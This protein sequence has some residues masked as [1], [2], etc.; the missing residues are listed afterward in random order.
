MSLFQQINLPIQLVER[1]YQLTIY[2]GDLEHQG[3]PGNKW[4]KLKHNIQAAKLAGAS[5]IASFGGPFSNHLHALANICADYNMQAVAVVRGELQLQLTPTLK[6]VV[7]QGGLLWPS[8]RSDYRKGMFSKVKSE[9]EHYLG[10]CYWIPEGGSN[11]LGVQ[12]CFEWSQSIY[13]KGGHDFPHWVISA[14]TGTTSAGFLANAHIDRLHVIPAI[15]GGEGLLESIMHD[16]KCLNQTIDEKRLS[17]LADYHCGGYAKLP[18][19]LKDV[20]V[21]FSE[22]NP[23]IQFDPVYTAKVLF[24]VVTEMREGRWPQDNTLL[25]HTG[26]L[27]GLR[28]YPPIL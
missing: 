11:A 5:H 1:G 3:A 28:G 7:N 26:G 16:A 13:E 22:L 24:G 6:D 27:Q 4:H 12:G 19:R 25:I 14:G 23:Q 20:I 2:R 17:I 21:Q 9:I 18:R 15:K 10:E 8:L